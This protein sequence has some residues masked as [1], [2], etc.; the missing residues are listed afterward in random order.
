[1]SA[2]K[3]AILEAGKPPAPLIERFGRYPA[4]FQT[5]LGN[6]FDYASYD[7]AAG[8]LPVDPAAHDA[9]VITGSPAAT[10]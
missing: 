4:M 6:G 10:S 2:A 7:V 5:L 9:Y 8:E 3:V 1:M